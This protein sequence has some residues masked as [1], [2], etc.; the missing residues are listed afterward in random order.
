[1]WNDPRVVGLGRLIQAASRPPVGAGRISLALGL[2]LMCHITFATAVMAMITAMFFGLSE[3]LGRVAWPLAGLVNA[4]LILQFPLA[5]SL[6]LTG[7]GGRARG[8]AWRFEVAHDRHCAPSLSGG[9]E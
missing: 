3:C 2:G 6:L 8:R 1:M 5:H 7:P 9:P 4:A